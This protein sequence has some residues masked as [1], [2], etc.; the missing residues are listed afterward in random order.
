MR[1]LAFVFGL[2]VLALAPPAASQ[3]SLLDQLADLRFPEVT[4]TVSPTLIQV[5]GAQATV[6]GETAS[7]LRKCIDN[8][9]CPEPLLARASTGNGDGVVTSDEAQDFSI[10]A[11]AGLN[12]AGGPV[13][14]FRDSIK[15][16]VTIDDVAAE[17]V[18]FR[19]FEI[20]NAEGPVRSTGPIQIT[21]LLHVAF[22]E[23]GSSRTHHVRILRDR[24]DIELADRIVVHTGK[25][26]TLEKNTIEPEGMRLY[27]HDGEIAGT[28][29]QLQ[30]SDPLTFSIERAGLST[31]GWIALVS[32]LLVAGGLGAFYLAR[33]RLR[34]A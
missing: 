17:R 21:L 32:L 6:S 15:Q 4:L 16:L 27:Y 30:G 33:R 14:E 2:A 23:A 1:R 25:G 3:D 22:P 34:K 9:D 29:S 31:G 18:E 24:S 11:K 13:A 20:A 7:D 19:R 12:I 28:Q 10:A 26:W 8:S 5:D